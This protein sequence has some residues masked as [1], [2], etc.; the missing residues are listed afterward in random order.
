MGPPE[1]AA[2]KPA[3]VPAPVEIDAAS[4]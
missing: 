2:S 4:L 3:P 1:S